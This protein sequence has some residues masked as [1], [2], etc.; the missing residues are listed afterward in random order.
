MID[1]ISQALAHPGLPWLVVAAFAGGLARGFAGFG[2]A[3]VFI[4]VA[5]LFL[6]P[7]AAITAMVVMDVFGPM[8]LL[9][10]AWRDADRP[11]LLVLALG[12]VIGIPLGTI[13]LTSLDPVVFRWAVSLICFV[14]LALLASGWRYN[15]KPGRGLVFGLGLIAGFMGGLAGL[16]GPFVILF[17][18]SGRR[19]ISVIRGVSMLFLF[20]TDIIVVSTFALRGLLSVDF[21]MLGLVCSVPLAAGAMLGQ[22][23][24]NPEKAALF[25]MVA[26][27]LIAIA[28]SVGLPLFD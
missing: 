4:P 13:A 24:F 14:L 11:E 22:R 8:P 12:G 9:K 21:L 23:L 6:H 28:A 27:T 18:L 3:M 19:A 1:A 17:Y 10:R 2:T 16:P 7:V 15:G 20:S 25:R 26:Y 5:S